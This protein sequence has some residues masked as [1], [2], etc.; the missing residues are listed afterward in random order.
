MC[1]QTHNYKY[2]TTFSMGTWAINRFL[3]PPLSVTTWGSAGELRSLPLKP[4]FSL[5]PGDNFSSSS[6]NA[7]WIWFYSDVSPTDNLPPA[8]HRHI[9]IYWN[10]DSPSWKCFKPAGSALKTM[11]QLQTIHLWAQIS[12]LNFSANRVSIINYI[13]L[14]KWAELG[15][16]G[17]AGSTHIAMIPGAPSAETSSQAALT[18]PGEHEL[19]IAVGSA[20]GLMP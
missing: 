2:L 12:S 14:S 20:G 7:T 9:W 4:K 5:L 15:L 3:R 19:N 13:L 11:C 17:S 6:S 16:H 8:V 18:Q 1:S 10:M